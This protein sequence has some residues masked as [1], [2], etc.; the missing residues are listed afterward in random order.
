MKRREML[1]LGFLGALAAA[2]PNCS[3]EYPFPGYEGVRV[4]T[5]DTKFSEEMFQPFYDA[6]DSQEIITDPTP[7]FPLINIA[8]QDFTGK[9]IPKSIRQTF[10]PPEVL[11]GIHPKAG[12]GYMVYYNVVLSEQEPM[13][14]ETLRKMSHEFGHVHDD[15]YMQGEMSEFPS[16][17][18]EHS[19]M[20]VI[21]KYRPV[22]KVYADSELTFKQF[23]DLE[24]TP[25]VVNNPGNLVDRTWNAYRTG[26][27][28]YTLELINAALRTS[29]GNLQTALAEMEQMSIKDMVEEAQAERTP[30]EM[31]AILEGSLDA[32]E[33]EIRKGGEKVTPII[34]EGQQIAE[35][36][37]VQEMFDYL[38]TKNHNRSKK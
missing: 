32:F 1:K 33:G 9:K 10:V 12:G 24:L 27:S 17:F 7:F 3:P 28:I 8:Y 18:F 36:N 20:A 37:Y 35:F 16:V 38:R 31:Y 13:N 2:L 23:R 21:E 34:H 30:A 19:M 22:R 14:S 26:K 15:Q 25:F 6:Y 11:Q 29:T 5:D 4:R